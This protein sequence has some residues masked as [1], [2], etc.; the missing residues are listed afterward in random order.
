M[1]AVFKL[2]CLA[3]QYGIVDLPGHRG[4]QLVPLG[5]DLVIRHAL[6]F[7]RPEGVQADVQRHK[8]QLHPHPPQAHQQVRGKMQAG[9]R[10]RHRAVDLAVD[11]LVA[12]WVS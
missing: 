5:M 1:K 4:G 3:L 12:L 8:G 9:R 7:H 11:G 2:T 10:S 6:L